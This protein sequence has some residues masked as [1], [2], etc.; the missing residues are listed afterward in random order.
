MML[1]L[2]VGFNFYFSFSKA[3]RGLVDVEA[4]G[5]GNGIGSFNLVCAK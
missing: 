1:Y 2:T 3:A 5:E 4:M